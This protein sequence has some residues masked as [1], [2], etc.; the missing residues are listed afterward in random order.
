MLLNEDIWK[1]PILVLCYTNH[2]LDQFLE[3]ILQ[4]NDSIVRVGSRSK[5]AALEKYNLS[6]K[7]RNVD[8][9][10]GIRANFYQ[11]RQEMKMEMEKIADINAK[12]EATTKHVF[13]EFEL[14]Q[15]MGDGLRMLERKYDDHRLQRRPKSCIQEWLGLG[16]TS[17]SGFPEQFGDLSLE[18]NRDIDQPVEVADRGNEEFIDAVEDAAFEENKRIL[19]IDQIDVQEEDIL[20][21]LK[22]RSKVNLKASIVDFDDETEDPG[23]DG[24]QLSKKEIKRR[25]KMVPIELAKESIMNEHEKKA[26]ERNPWLL[27]PRERWT[28]Y[29]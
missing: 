22:D 1:G 4:F 27:N 20:K 23:D 28:L 24:W 10:R 21:K 3:G 15:F 2:A 26:A 7:R 11:T 9:P 16:K 14:E 29:R 8:L 19:D 17:D 12:M 6:N 5:N 25:K 18:K 13:S